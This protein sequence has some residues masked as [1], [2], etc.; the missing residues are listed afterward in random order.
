[1]DS[2][3]KEAPSIDFDKLEAKPPDVMADDRILLAWHR[4]HM[5]NERT[6]LSW[7]RT[8]LGLLGFGFVMERF[9]IFI[10]HLMRLEGIKVHQQPS[11][12]IVLLSVMAFVLAGTLILASGLRF[13]AIRR[14]INR[15]EAVFSIL[16]EFLVAAS[17]VVIIGMAVILSLPSIWEM[18]EF[19][20][21]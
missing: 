18:T 17:V 6:F 4:S 9:D 3:E 2:P 5:A 10:R 15:G 12:P 11:D 20:A 19:L 8:S 1:M 7:S 16:P 13:L 21:K 14:H